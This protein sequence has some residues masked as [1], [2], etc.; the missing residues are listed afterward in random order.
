MKA[1]NRLSIIMVVS[2]V[3]FSLNVLADPLPA[4]KKAMAAENKAA[5]AGYSIADRARMKLDRSTISRAVVD[6]PIIETARYVYVGEKPLAITNSREE[7]YRGQRVL[8]IK[9]PDIKP[10]TVVPGDRLKVWEGP[11]GLNF[12]S[13]LFVRIP[14]NAPEAAFV[15]LALVSGLA[16]A[17][18]VKEPSSDKAVVSLKPKVG[19][20]SWASKPATVTPAVSAGGGTQ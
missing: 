7:Y 13:R 2:V 18:E 15:A 5:E 12:P 20:D 14:K 17:D 6:G 9:V 8:P 16:H 19:A 3:M 10:G 11:R 1:Q 4:A